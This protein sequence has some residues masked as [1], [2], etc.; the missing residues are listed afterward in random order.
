M[1]RASSR[2]QDTRRLLWQSPKSGH[3]AHTD[4]HHSRSPPD[5]IVAQ[6]GREPL[7]TKHDQ[8]RASR[9]R[10]QP[11]PALRLVGATSNCKVGDPSW[12][13]KGI[14]AGHLSCG[15]TGCADQ[16]RGMEARIRP[17]MAARSLTG[18]KSKKRARGGTAS[19]HPRSGPTASCHGDRIRPGREGRIRP[20]TAVESSDGFGFNEEE[21]G[22]WDGKKTGKTKG[23]ANGSL[24]A[25]PLAAV[26]GGSG[27]R[28]VGG[29]R[30]CLAA[31]WSRLP[32]LGIQAFL[33][34]EG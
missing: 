21:D 30:R 8:M 25:P 19:H 29:G 4:E 28:S 26:A 5:T 9:R 18:V 23:L 31:G 17:W 10:I 6:I 22:A 3:E 2:A 7:P 14:A 24:Q 34:S 33:V 27:R 15:R 20:W 12:K 1:A 32:F 13:K 11:R 16:I